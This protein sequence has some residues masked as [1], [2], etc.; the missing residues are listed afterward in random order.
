[1]YINFQAEIYQ[2]EGETWSN[3]NFQARKWVNPGYDWNVVYWWD[4]QHKH[5][6]L[7]YSQQNISPVSSKK[8]T[9]HDKEAAEKISFCVH[10]INFDE[11]K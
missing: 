5:N 1:M 11:G 6:R 9:Q 4:N 2:W 10:I 3:F 8:H 7:L